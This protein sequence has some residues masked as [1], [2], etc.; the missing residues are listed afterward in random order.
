MRR[1]PL[2]LACPCRARA[3][4]VV[5]PTPSPAATALFSSPSLGMT[6]IISCSPL[7]LVVLEKAAPQRWSSDGSDTWAARIVASIVRGS[8]VR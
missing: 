4:P 1:G 6:G 2:L 5:T 8:S 3:A 7:R